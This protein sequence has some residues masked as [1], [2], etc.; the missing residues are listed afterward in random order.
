MDDRDSDSKKPAMIIHEDLE[1]EDPNAA[2]EP[3][4]E[5]N[6]FQGYVLSEEEE[7]DPRVRC[8]ESRDPEK[9]VIDFAGDINFDEHYSNMANYRSKGMGM[10]GV[11]SDNLLKE[12]NDADIFMINNEFPYSD[13]GTPTPGK[14]FTFR[15]RPSMVSNLTEMG[16]DI[17]G[18]A[19]NHAYDHGPDALLDTFATLTGAGIPYVGAGRDL[20]EARSPF[21]YISGG[22]KIAFVAATQI[23]RSSPPDTKEAT[24]TSP[25]VLRTLDPTGFLEVIRT[26][27]DN[28][29]LTIVFV[30]WGSENTYDI[31]ASQRSL[32]QQYVQAGADLI[33]GAHSHCLQGF[34][35]INGVPVLYSMGNF[36]FSSKDLDSCVIQAIASKTAVPSDKGNSNT[37]RIES[38]RFIPCVQHNCRTDMYEKGSS[39]YDRLLGAM[40]S[41]SYDVSIDEDGFISP[42]SGH[43]VAPVSPKPLARKSY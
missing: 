10:A 13:R 33:I 40:T 25:G 7:N 43:G 30:H 6:S 3:E 20:Q 8:L 5:E 35:Y 11:L 2:I 34:E 19:N 31:D 24:E 18:L 1:A 14:K 21:Y 9:V 41:L 38:V 4:I 28:A 42:G 27:E 37:A 22:I 16:V 23:E 39:E 36:W 15:A 12:L 32:A 26:A 29:D 17:A